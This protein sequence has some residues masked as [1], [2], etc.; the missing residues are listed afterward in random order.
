LTQELYFNGVNGTTGTYGLAPLRV[1]A[2]ARR[3]LEDQ[4]AT[5]RRLRRLR[6]ELSRQNDV[7][8][9]LLE[10][11]Q[12]LLNHD[13]E[14]RTAGGNAPDGDIDVIAAQ[15]LE[16]VW[17][18]HGT[19]G[20]GGV[21]AFAYRLRR[22][23]GATIRH[24]AELISRAQSDELVEFLGG[25]SVEDAG[26]LGR[27]LEARLDKMLISIQQIYL[28]PIARGRDSG[29]VHVD[30]DWIEG[31]CRML[32]Q[33]PVPALQEARSGER[34]GATV[35]TLG[36]EF[37]HPRR[38]LADPPQA[39]RADDL[40]ASLRRLS[41]L[42][43]FSSWYEIV[44]ALGG[45]LLDLDRCEAGVRWSLICTSLRGWL[46]ELR[47]CV[48]GRLGTVPWI[49]PRD[50]RQAGWGMILPAAAS[51]VWCQGLQDA[52]APLL[53]LRQA[54]SGP[55]FALYAGKDGY[56][57]GDTARAFLKRP[58]RNA[59]VASPADPES[60]GVPYYL[61][62][63]GSPEKIP[64]SF[65]YQLDVQYAV[66][67]IDFGDD[68]DAYRNYALNVVAAE[69]SDAPVSEPH[70]VF[71]AVQNRGDRASELSAE[72]L[73]APLYRYLSARRGQ[74]PWRFTHVASGDAS[75][76]NLVDIMKRDPPPAFLFVACHGLEFDNE[77][78]R[79]ET[80]QGAL[81]CRDWQ[82]ELGEVTPDKFL[83][84]RDISPEMNLQGQIAFLFACYSAGT[85]RYDE[86]TH[87]L[88][89]EQ[90]HLIAE[91]PFSAALPQ[92]ML[93][94]RDHGALAVV[95]HVERV[96]SLS[97]LSDLPDYPED[98]APRKPEHLQV[99]TSAFERLLDGYPVGAALDFFNLRY[100]ALATELTHLYERTSDPPTVAD[101]YRL[102]DLWT[103]HNDARG[104][105]VIGD[106]AVRIRTSIPDR[107]V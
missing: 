85:P 4:Y 33:M 28:N 51:Q 93:R 101:A 77:D 91:K 92:A 73:V 68:W 20:A 44:D 40:L 70:G 64:F 23:P 22:A 48:T 86:Y 60:T 38:F 7:S 50:L 71:F 98:V 1:T 66:G 41:K 30:V 54:E 45:V 18:E 25:G 90:G 17:G 100:A 13:L 10:I 107:S 102:A 15:L 74:G 27:I 8:Q 79:Q 53:Q 57:L 55:Y 63:A 35:Y 52:L 3:I 47:R 106:P 32:A 39:R 61:L 82:G 81:L 29:D 83:S 43:A 24:V 88:F 19:L 46:D 84:A 105:V 56:R 2:L 16:V 104:F 58:P 97:F 34:I 69:Q 26:A 9:K 75:K 103:A 5:E 11:I 42:D 78:R 12:L 80:D 37:S 31:L 87:R 21:E 67:R 14:L 36:R 96:W 76:A 65:Q 89:K 99:F 49:E 94:L 59:D 95:G 6:Q 62:L 72:H